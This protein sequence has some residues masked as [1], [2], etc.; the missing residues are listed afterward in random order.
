MTL[1]FWICGVF[2]GGLL[3][4]LWIGGGLIPP[5]HPA[6]APLQAAKPLLSAFLIVLIVVLWRVLAP[7]PPPARDGEDRGPEPPRKT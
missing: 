4:A 1:R 2:F 3:A 5:E 7:S 6:H